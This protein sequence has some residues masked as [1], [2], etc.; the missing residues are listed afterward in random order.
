MDNT[1]AEGDNRS[2]T[3]NCVRLATIVP[4]SSQ[5]D[6]NVAIHEIHRQ[7]RFKLHQVTFIEDVVDA[8]SEEVFTGD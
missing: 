7:S 1:F 5:R 6:L 2:I 3:T 8:T 4:E